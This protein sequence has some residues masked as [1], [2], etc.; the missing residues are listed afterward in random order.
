[1][2]RR[3]TQVMLWMSPGVP[4]RQWDVGPSESQDVGG[5]RLKSWEVV[6]QGERAVPKWAVRP[7]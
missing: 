4:G 2:R 6:E 3:V 7:M 1:M 5:L